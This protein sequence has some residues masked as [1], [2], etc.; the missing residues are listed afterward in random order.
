MFFF[1]LNLQIFEAIV[2][3]V[4][5]DVMDYFSFSRKMSGVFP[6]HQIMLVAIFS[7]VPFSRI[8]FRRF[9]QYIIPVFQSLPPNALPTELM[10][11]IPACG[12]D[13][14]GVGSGTVPLSPASSPS[15]CGYLPSTR[16][17][18]SDVLVISARLELSIT[19]LR[20]LRPILLDEE[21]MW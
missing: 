19:S 9:D 3:F 2:V 12:M 16:P 21:T 20:G 1:V 6:V 8:L 4:V 14:A 17:R 5:V 11:H 10:S 13:P 18:R 7:S 15:I